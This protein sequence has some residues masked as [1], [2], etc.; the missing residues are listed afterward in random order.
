MGNQEDFLFRRGHPGSAAFHCILQHSATTAHVPW[1]SHC[2]ATIDNFCLVFLQ[3][4]NKT[5]LQKKQRK[6]ETKKQYVVFK[7]YSNHQPAIA[8]WFIME[9]PI[10][11]SGESHNTFFLI[12]APSRCRIQSPAGGVFRNGSFC[13]VRPADASKKRGKKEAHSETMM[14][15]WW[16][17]MN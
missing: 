16:L 5:K 11:K 17:M 13:V 9:N 8:G 7:W 2:F 15:Y 4:L 14:N 3:W 10:E 12:T 1:F 6:Q